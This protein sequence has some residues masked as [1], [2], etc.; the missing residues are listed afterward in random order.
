M[1]T[2]WTELIGPAVVAAVVSGVVGIAGFIVNRRTLLTMHREKLAA[3][4]E[5]AERKVNSEISLAER[6]LEFDRALTERRVDADIALAER[7]FSLDRALADWKCKSEF[8]EQI[9]SD[10]Y[11]ARD[12]VLS[13]RSPMSW[14]GEGETRPRI[15]G[16]TDDERRHRDAI[17]AP[18]ERLSRER[19]FLTELHAKRYRFMAL[20]GAD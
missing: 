3:D 20:F 11:K 17:Y 16:E 8:A 7:K 19:D 13:A 12:I 2:E 18:F 9:L 6:R 10:F 1:A 4:R 5:Q 15:E 14:A